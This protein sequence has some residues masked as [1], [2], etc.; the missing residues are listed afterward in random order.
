MGEF[1][2]TDAD[3]SVYMV[4]A[5]DEATAISDF[6]KMMSSSQPSSAGAQQPESA[7]TATPGTFEDS[8]LSQGLSGVN[9]GIAG[10]A[11]LPGDAMNFVSDNLGFGKPFGGSQQFADQLAEVGAIGRPSED[12]F[13]QIARSV[14][15]AA[16][17]TAVP[18]LGLVGAGSRS[19]AAGGN[20]VAQGG[21]VV[22]QAASNAARGA[23]SRPGLFAA[24]EAGA[25]VG[26]G[27][28][29]SVLEQGGFS[30]AAQAVGGLIG[31]VAGGLPFTPRAV[32]RGA[33]SRA[34]DLLA[35]RLADDGLTPS[36]LRSLDDPGS[37]VRTVD[38]A[39]DNVRGVAGAV[40]RVP[41]EGKARLRRSARGVSEQEPDNLI[42]DFD[43]ALRAN[44]AEF[45][46]QVK[47]IN[48][49]RKELS[50]PQYQRA[51]NT[52][53]DLSDGAQAL[54]RRPAFKKAI[55]EAVERAEDEGI[56]FYDTSLV[57][58]LRDDPGD[59]VALS[60]D[61]DAIQTREEVGQFFDRY[62]EVQRDVNA[63]QKRPASAAIKAIGGIHP[64]GTLAG[65]LRSRGI[66]P[67]TAPGLFSRNGREQLDNLPSIE[68]P[69]LAATYGR[70]FDGFLDPDDIVD[71]LEREVGGNAVRSGDEAALL[72]EFDELDSQFSEFSQL[73]D[74]LG[75]APAAPAASRSKP[76]TMQGIDLI[77]RRLSARITKEANRAGPDMDEVRRLTALKN[78]FLK[79]VDASNPDYAQARAIFSENSA[80]VGAMAQGRKF[81]R[82][83]TEDLSNS[84]ESLTGPQKDAFR[85]GVARELRGLVQRP[86]T[87]TGL[88]N[89][90]ETVDRLALVMDEKKIPAFIKRIESRKAQRAGNQAI[91]GGSS[92]QGNRA[93]DDALRQGILE[94]FDVDMVRLMSGKNLAEQVLNGAMKAIA[95][96]KRK[97]VGNQTEAVADTLS[98]RL[99]ASPSE[100]ASSLEVQER[101]RAGARAARSGVTG[102]CGLLNVGRS[103]EPLQ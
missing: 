100:T 73:R 36:D 65:E 71:A 57:R 23:A 25:S 24:G 42:E 60:D 76:L 11:G 27:A 40:G 5:P 33:Q 68:H 34:D 8:H 67:R 70:G 43:G 74:D 2:L 94:R 61:L 90:P 84:F 14:G 62:R 63:L 72:R 39:G 102:A 16:G 45:G 101:A 64:R 75:P 46:E 10:L 31:G 103:L 79:E 17:S 81:M 3:G 12:G 52:E 22:S 58:G 18:G 6:Q 19:L 26:S 28:T 53:V 89:N 30:P 87:R 88:L 21:N 4:T 77:V 54:L 95:T 37:G 92:T 13:K 59:G 41:G 99:T 49:R 69:D 29:Q 15:N 47:A 7:P 98:K 91:Q 97:V 56:D 32:P 83:D 66:N 78:D 48:I 35:E 82:G 96:G 38:V 1:E 50:K 55:G 51:F 9:E 86:G 93:E 80:L 44:S 20:V 85:L